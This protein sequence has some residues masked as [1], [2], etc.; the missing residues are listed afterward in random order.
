MNKAFKELLPNNF[1]V[2]SRIFESFQYRNFRLYF[3][4]QCLSQ[5]GTWMQQI[6]MSWLIYNLTG[7]V[8]LLGMVVFLAQ[9]PMMILT[10]F[11][12]VLV[13]RFNKR[14]ILL[15][16]QS[17][18]MCLAATLAILVFTDTIQIWHIMTLSI[19]GGCI[20]AIDMP[21]RQSF[22][23]TLVPAEKLSN[24]IALNS[25]IING[26][27]LFGPA[28]AGVLIP[29]ISEGGCFLLNAISYVCVLIALVKIDYTHTAQSNK[30]FSVFSDF[31]EGFSY[32][33]HSFPI[34]TLL[35]T[36]SIFSFCVFTFT[37][38]I[39]A[40]I[41][42]ILGGDSRYLGLFMSCFGIGSFSAAMYLAARKSVLGLGK[43]VSIC[44]LLSSLSVIPLFHVRTIWVA[45]ILAVLLGFGLI[46]TVASCNTL[47]Q[48]I[49]TPSMRGRVMGYY[50]MGFVGAG[51]LGSL[52]WGWVSKFTNLP[53]AM[54][55]S[56]GICIIAA[57]VFE[58]VRPKIRKHT[59]HIYVSKGI[60]PEIAEG[61]DT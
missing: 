13:D 37:T 2:F 27:R 51:A 12:S 52:L 61:I 35:L 7:S 20:S 31:K 32:I 47:I 54:G 46:C 59:H 5:T 4:G 49:L 1:E 28:L 30:K 8:V 56:G 21:T 11:L 17:C 25:A 39:P 14:S 23:T 36:V 58:R 42:D 50:S 45:L 22:Y 48:T 34:R 18:A 41:K 57:I 3:T 15:V 26:A 9:I 10:P 33:Y 53:T 24:A 19:C 60:I 6:A 55:I 29:I 16:E 38:F 43:I 40:Y 44:M